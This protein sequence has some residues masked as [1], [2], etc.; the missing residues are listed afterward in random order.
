MAAVAEA[1]NS[2]Q[3]TAAA[4]ATATA[5]GKSHGQLICVFSPG[6]VAPPGKTTTTTTRQLGATLADHQQKLAIRPVVWLAHSRW[7][8]PA[9]AREPVRQ[10]VSLSISR[11]ALKLAIIRSEAGCCSLLFLPRLLV[12][13]ALAPGRV[14]E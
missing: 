6:A 10:Q 5:R 8:E 4:T 3:A 11:A 13:L 7:P 14:S 2:N 12:G 9:I 1:E